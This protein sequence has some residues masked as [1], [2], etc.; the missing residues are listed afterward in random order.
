MAVTGDFGKLKKLQKRLSD[1]AGTA[2][3][4][5]V[6]FAPALAEF[7]REEFATGTDPWGDPWKPLKA[8]TLAKGRT[9]PPLTASGNAVAVMTV[10][11]QGARDRASFPNYIR[12]HLSTGRSP[13]PLRG[14]AWPSRWAQKLKET[15]AQ[16][17][18]D[19]AEGR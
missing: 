5:A 6:K 11:A 3:K 12:Y 15:A 1:L 13:L 14:Q 8:N 9:P 2:E 19:I 4:A 10:T 16:A 17:I 18:S 7:I